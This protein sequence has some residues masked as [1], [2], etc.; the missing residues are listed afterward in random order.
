MP[1]K[2][3]LIKQLANEF[4]WTQAD[5]R[6][7]L[8]ASQ[9]IVNTREEAILCMIRYAGPDLKKRNYEVGSQKRINNQQKQQ[10][11]SIVE[12]LTKIHNFYANQLVPTLKATIQEQSNY[13]SDLLKQFGQDQGGKNGQ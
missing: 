9:Q 2:E 1:S 12:Q 4:N 8:D 7:A 11:S 13:I 3:E 5:I 6:R 10:I